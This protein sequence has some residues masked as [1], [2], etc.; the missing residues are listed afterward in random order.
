MY[1]ADNYSTVW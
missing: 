1:S